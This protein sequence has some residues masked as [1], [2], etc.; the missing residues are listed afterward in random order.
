MNPVSEVPGTIHQ[1][2]YSGSKSFTVKS[3]AFWKNRLL[4]K[5]LFVERYVCPKPRRVRQ[6][7]FGEAENSLHV[8]LADDSA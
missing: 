6:N 5:L 4:K 2:G 1:A 8:Q 7:V 3:Q